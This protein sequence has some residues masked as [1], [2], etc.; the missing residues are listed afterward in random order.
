ME[1]IKSR[2]VSLRDNLMLILDFLSEIGGP[3]EEQIDNYNIMKI[4][5]NFFIDEIDFHLRGD[6][7]SEQLM[8]YLGVYAIFYHRSRTELMK[9]LHEMCPNRHLNW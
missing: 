2:F 7:T 3:S 6:V 9:L 4:K 1:Y 8:E 5:T